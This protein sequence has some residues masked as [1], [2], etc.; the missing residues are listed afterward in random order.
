MVEVLA[1]ALTD[2]TATA[3]H[4]LGKIYIDFE[5][6]KMYKYVECDGILTGGALTLN[7]ALSWMDTAMQVTNDISAGIGVV[8]PAGVAISLIT[9]AYFGWIQI[10]GQATLIGDGLVA[11]GEAVVLDS[12]TDGTCDTMAAGE[13]HEVFAAALEADAAITYYFAAKLRSLV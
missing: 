11:A 12:V 5:K 4:T 7:H 6:G 1:R 13:E 2:F 10:S 3:V 9:Q 8:A